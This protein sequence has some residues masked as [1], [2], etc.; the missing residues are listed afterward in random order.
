MTRQYYSSGPF[1]CCYSHT[2]QFIHTTFIKC[3]FSDFTGAGTRE[4]DCKFLTNSL[5]V[6]MKLL[7]VTLMDNSLVDNKQNIEGMEKIA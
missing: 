4:N 6:S 7:P 1:T 3:L 5:E 2:R